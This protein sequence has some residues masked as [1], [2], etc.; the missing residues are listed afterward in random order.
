M[1]RWQVVALTL[2]SV[3]LIL[4]LG[5]PF[6]AQWSYK[7]GVQLHP[8]GFDLRNYAYYQALG[9]RLTRTTY[10][11]R[12]SSLQTQLVRNNWISQPVPNPQDSDWVTVQHLHFGRY[13]TSDAKVLYTYLNENSGQPNLEK[14]GQENP[15]GAEVMWNEIERATQG[16]YFLLIPDIIQRMTEETAGEM[17]RH[18]FADH[19]GAARP[20]KN[21]PSATTEDRERAIARHWLH[22]YLIQRY[23]EV[24]Q[25]A[26]D[27][28]LWDK[29]Y[30]A[31]QQID[32][33]EGDKS[34][35]DQLLDQIPSE[36]KTAAAESFQR[37][38]ISD[39]P[40]R[41]DSE[42]K[43][44]AKDKDK[45]STSGKE[46]KSDQDDQPADPEPGTEGE[47]P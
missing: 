40:P 38:K 19:P 13:W 7:E 2:L 37:T 44:E 11:S 3:L 26:A 25:A 20:R 23:G 15:R 17:E 18:Y 5:L 33:L 29:T 22:P 42:K 27:A 32:R 4:I 6:M 46:T 47:M 28:R 36:E 35:V 34:A 1:P 9:L 21:E 30:F 39:S 8:V 24:G 16:G 12:Y 43:D 41:K 10:T 31:G 14:W 45:K